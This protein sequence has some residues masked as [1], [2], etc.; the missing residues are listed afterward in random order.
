MSLYSA[1]NAIFG[2]NESD[3]RLEK[4]WNLIGRENELICLPC[5][6]IYSKRGNDYDVAL[7]Y[8]HGKFHAIDATCPHLGGPLDEIVDLEMLI[9]MERPHAMCPWHLYAY[10]LETGFSPQGLTVD[11]YET[12]LKEG[13]LFILHRDELSL[14][15]YETEV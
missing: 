9:T 13:N 8:V 2:S 15:P 10:D 7:Y 12:K 14:H 3:P 5:R 11:V 1:I 4:K 6:R